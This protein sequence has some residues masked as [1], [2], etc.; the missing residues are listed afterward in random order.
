[1]QSSRHCDLAATPVPQRGTRLC[2]SLTAKAPVEARIIALV[3]TASA[4][5]ASMASAASTSLRAPCTCEQARLLRHATEYATVPSDVV[6]N[7]RQI[8]ATHAVHDMLQF[9]H[10]DSHEPAYASSMVRNCSQALACS[11]GGIQASK[12]QERHAPHCRPCST[13]SLPGSTASAHSS[14]PLPRRGPCPPGLPVVA[15]AR[16]RSVA[17][18]YTC[19]PTPIQDGGFPAKSSVQLGA[20]R[21][22]AMARAAIVPPHLVVA[23]HGRSQAALEDVLCILGFQRNCSVKIG[24]GSLRK[25]GIILCTAQLQSTD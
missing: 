19:V 16:A 20:L 21:W 1:M 25:F 17:Q 2:W 24:H 3:I 13:S 15:M 7:K 18:R 23:E 8:S 11:R 12:L 10:G 5:D 9:T 14:G 6:P 4:H 22:R